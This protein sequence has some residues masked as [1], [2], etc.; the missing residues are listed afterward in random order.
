MGK[1]VKLAKTNFP[2]K[3]FAMRKVNFPSF[4]LR[5]ILFLLFVLLNANVLLSQS[6]RAETKQRLFDHMKE[7]NK[8]WSKQN[9]DWPILDQE[10]S[11]PSDRF[12]IQMHLFLVE[13]TLRE[14][15]VAHLST[16]QIS[17]RMKFLDI[18]KEY[19]AKGIFPQNIY[20]SNRQPYFVDH[21]ETA[22][23]VGHLIQKSGSS[24][25][26]EKIKQENNYAYLA[27]LEFQYP[28]IGSWADEN[29]FTTDELAW[30]QPGYYPA[31]Q[32]YYPI[33]NGGGV[34]GKIN[35]M[36][37][38][39][40]GDILYLAGDF[41][42][43]DG[44][45]AN[46]IIAW[47]GDN[48][49]PL[50]E[51]VNGEI[52]TI[53]SGSNDDIYIGGNFMLNSDPSYSN[54]ALWNGES[55]EGLQE[56]EM[57]GSVYALALG[58]GGLIVGG[59]FQ[60][61]DNQSIKYLARYPYNDNLGWNNSARWIIPGTIEYEYIPN[62]FSV[63]GPVYSLQNIDGRIL[64]GGSFSSTGIDVS[65]PDVN[66]LT[67]QNLA[68]WYNENWEVGLTPNLASVRSTFLGSDGKIYAGGDLVDTLENLGILNAGFWEYGWFIQLNS[69]IGE[70]RFHGFVEHNESI[71]AFGDIV[72]YWSFIASQGFV[73]VGGE[74]NHN[75]QPGLG[76]VFNKPVR[77]AEVFQD[78]I[79]FAGDFTSV[80]SSSNYS[81]LNGL[82]KSPFE[83]GTNTIREGVFENR[84]IQIYNYEN[85]LQVRYENLEKNTIL[86]LFNLQGQ[87]L[88]IINL[89]QGNQDLSIGL[90]EWPSGMYVYQVFND[91]GKQ[92][93]KF[94]IN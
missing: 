86:H 78:E 7:I 53:I 64:L 72:P 17:K 41:S 87:L 75:V 5:S 18:L 71:F 66:Q 14:R 80:L 39:R 33:G 42:E 55:W 36:K 62:A 89:P 77:A 93:G 79:Y 20:H 52:H 84:I 13:K 88:K 65:E 44:V 6:L 48:W 27:Q 25:L 85:Q 16:W 24:D 90:S 50:G 8:E 73:L 31:S 61:I 51:G 10:I 57:E 83:I 45:E 37:T 91:T 58:A 76:A 35:V 56:G 69:S 94:H 30:I 59:D 15:K 38:D 28:E 74:P 82:A 19:A 40:D 23:A 81:E 22:C 70:N 4:I 1:L 43:V 92:S 47:D 60:S 46:S 26:V 29:G 21:L 54:I 12:R 32:A 3:L 67:T 68:Y 11:F 9:M 2:L 34:D 49:M 63:D